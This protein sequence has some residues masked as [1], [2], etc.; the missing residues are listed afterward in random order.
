MIA[1]ADFSLMRGDIEQA[2][3]MLRKI[4]AE[5]RWIF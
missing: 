1:N 2:L 5:Q 3:G 4:T